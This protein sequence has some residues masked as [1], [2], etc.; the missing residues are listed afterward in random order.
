M[1][2]MLYVY[3]TLPYSKQ[4]N[5]RHISEI[6][7][8]WSPILDKILLDD[9]PMILFNQVKYQS[10]INFNATFGREQIYEF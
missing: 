3:K 6:F 8:P 2:Q 7:E 5:W 1:E 10:K 4:M 9:D